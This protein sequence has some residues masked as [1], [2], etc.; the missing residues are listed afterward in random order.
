MTVQIPA[1]RTQ[2]QPVTCFCR[3]PECLEKSTD[4]HYQWQTDQTPVVCPKCGACLAPMVGVISLVHFLIRDKQGPIVGHG[5]L[6]YAFACS[7]TR[8]HLATYT[9]DEAATGELHAVNCPGC[10]L[11]AAERGLSLQGFAVYAKPNT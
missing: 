3:N 7:Q 6:R 8:A 9:N 4:S 11:A 2:K 10:L 5:G 1:D